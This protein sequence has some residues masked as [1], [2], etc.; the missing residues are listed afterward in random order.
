MVT[1][2][3]FNLQCCEYLISLAQAHIL[4][5]ESVYEL[6]FVF[7]HKNDYS[8]HEISIAQLFRKNYFFQ[9]YKAFPYLEVWYFVFGNFLRHCLVQ[10]LHYEHGKFDTNMSKERTQVRFRTA[11]LTTSLLLFLMLSAC[12][13]RFPYSLGELKD[14]LKSL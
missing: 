4:S 8:L 2:D 7:S 10:F 14:K 9:H 3:S 1:R 12:H 6:A 11:K 5:R 13:I